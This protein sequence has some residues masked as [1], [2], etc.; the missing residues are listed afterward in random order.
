MQKTH[1]DQV[2][3]GDLS[4]LLGICATKFSEEDQKEFIF[5]D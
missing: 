5:T 2:I 1:Q 3:R 4:K